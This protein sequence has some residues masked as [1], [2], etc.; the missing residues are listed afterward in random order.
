MMITKKTA[1]QLCAR[2]G[3]ARIELTVEAQRL[4]DLYND[5][6]VSHEEKEKAKRALDYMIESLE[7]K[8]ETSR[9]ARGQKAS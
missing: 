2:A 1:K 8:A 7:K 3:I 4:V 6:N 9:V 5:P